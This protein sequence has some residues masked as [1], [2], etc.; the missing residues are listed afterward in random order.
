[1]LFGFQLD[2]LWR[3]TRPVLASEEIYFGFRQDFCDFGVIFLAL[4]EIFG[5]VA[6]VGWLKIP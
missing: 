1:M 2:L 3:P 4:D 5:Q 6:D